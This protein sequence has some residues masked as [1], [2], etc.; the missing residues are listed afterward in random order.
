MSFRALGDIG[1]RFRDKR[2]V[3]GPL[4]QKSL[5]KDVAF[6]EILH[7]SMTVAE[8]FRRSF[9]AILRIEYEQARAKR[10]RLKPDL[11]SLISVICVYFRHDFANAIYMIHVYHQYQHS[12]RRFCNIL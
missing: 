11:C 6:R 1:V 9:W 5:P 10:S 3:L 12:Y 4:S 7:I 8:L 2:Q